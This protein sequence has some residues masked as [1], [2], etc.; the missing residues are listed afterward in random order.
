MR[1][2]QDAD[3]APYITHDILGWKKIISGITPY[4]FKKEQII[5]NQFNEDHKIILVKNGIVRMTFINASG[6]EHIN[7]FGAEGYVFGFRSCLSGKPYAGSLIAHTNCTVYKISGDFVTMQMQIDIDFFS[8]MMRSE[9]ERG[10]A[11]TRKAEMLTLPTTNCKLACTILSLANKI[12]LERKNGIF[13]PF[14]ITHEQ[15]S[16]IIYCDRVTVSRALSKF[17]KADLITKTKNGLLVKDFN[18]LADLLNNA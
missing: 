11:Y 18:R 4:K 7:F 15:L 16:Q 17:K 10:I 8:Y 1:T 3:Y 5:A 12:G 14:I 9:Y 2:F 6:K 13:I